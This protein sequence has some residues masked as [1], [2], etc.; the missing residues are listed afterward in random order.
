MMKNFENPLQ[1]EQEIGTRVFSRTQVI[2]QQAGESSEQLHERLR[3]EI[4][5]SFQS[6]EKPTIIR[7]PSWY[8]FDLS[9]IGI[10]EGVAICT[11]TCKHETPYRILIGRRRDQF[12][13]TIET[14][15]GDIYEYE[16]SPL[17]RELTTEEK[18]SIYDLM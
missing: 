6:I 10:P 2:R 17:G 15:S 8:T 11:S 18:N 7:T 9:K 16:I 13:K 4:L 3:P 5:N 12:M 1:D 14:S